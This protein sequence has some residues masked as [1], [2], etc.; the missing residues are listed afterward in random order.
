[1]VKVLG[2]VVV[3]VGIVLC[4][5]VYGFE[6]EENGSWVHGLDELNVTELSFSDSYGV[7]A[8]ASPMMVGLTLIQ[9]AAAKG[10]GIFFTLFFTYFC[11]LTQM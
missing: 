10:A 7:S 5:W 1:M 2:V 4:K 9:G 8:A 6:F 11:C 3:I